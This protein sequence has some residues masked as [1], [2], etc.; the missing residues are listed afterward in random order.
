MF[1]FTISLCY[2]AVMCHSAVCYCIEC[3]HTVCYWV[4]LHSVLSYCVLLGKT[5]YFWSSCF[6][7]FEEWVLYRHTQCSYF[8]VA[9]NTTIK[10][11]LK[12]KEFRRKEPVMVGKALCG[13]A[14]GMGSCVSFVHRDREWEQEVQWDHTFSK[15]SPN[16]LSHS[17]KFHLLKS[18]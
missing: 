18:P 4:F 5:F 10:S 9:V 1:T 17:A 16:D 8:S 2:G 14:A 12:K 13:M 15:L 6:L 11:N 7:L 3:Y